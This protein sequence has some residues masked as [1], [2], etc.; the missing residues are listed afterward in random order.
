M[1]L[2]LMKHSPKLKNRVAAIN[3]RTM[4]L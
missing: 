2:L 3:P 1:A 4:R